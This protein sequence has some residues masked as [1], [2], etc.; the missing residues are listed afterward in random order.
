MIGSDIK[1][2]TERIEKAIEAVIADVAKEKHWVTHYGAN[3]IHPQHLVYWIC[4]QSDAEKKR[5]EDNSEL[6]RKL[7]SLLTEHH[8]PLAGREQVHIGFESQETVDRESGGN[9]YHHWK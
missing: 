8:Y 9:W 4:V 1:E 6:Y 3:N 7:R 2:V 5:L